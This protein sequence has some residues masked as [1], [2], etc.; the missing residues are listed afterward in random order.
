MA[1]RYR[2]LLTD[3]TWVQFQLQLYAAAA[4]D[5]DCRELGQRGMASLWRMVSDAT[6]ED[7]AAVMQFLSMGM[8][9]NVLATLDMPYAADRDQLPAEIDEWSR[10]T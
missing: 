5:P 7:P 2:Q 4:T 10:K 8:L 6:G 1:N 3:T 9:L